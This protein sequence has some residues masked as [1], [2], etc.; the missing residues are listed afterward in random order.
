[1]PRW[2]KILL[3]NNLYTKKQFL[4][5]IMREDEFFDHIYRRK[6]GDTFIPEGKIKR[7]DIHAWIILSGASW[8]F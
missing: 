8:I 1:M 2:P 5:F 6:I 4:R 7:D 3:R